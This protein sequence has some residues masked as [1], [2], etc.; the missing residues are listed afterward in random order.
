MLLDISRQ[1]KRIIRAI[2]AIPL[3]LTLPI[4]RLDDALGESWALPFQAC[5]DWFV[6]L[7]L[8]GGRFHHLHLK[9]FKNI[10]LSVV[11]G[12]GRV[13]ASW[14]AHDKFLITSAKT[15]LPLLPAHW[16]QAVKAGIHL[17]QAIVIDKKATAQESCPFPLC[18]GVL[19]VEM[20]N[21]NGKVWYVITTPQRY[22]FR[23]T[24]YS[25]TN[26]SSCGKWSLTMIQ[27]EPLVQTE[28]QVKV[29]E[30]R[31]HISLPPPLGPQPIPRIEVQDD[32]I[33]QFRRVQLY[34]PPPK[35]HSIQEARDI[36]GRDN[37]NAPA[38]RYLGWWHLRHDMNP[39]LA[40]YAL[41]KAAKSSMTSDISISDWY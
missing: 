6:S 40:I 5:T 26:S 18:S 39:K 27:I 28:D 10:L 7:L 15:G 32:A 16:K 20:E 14:V 19:K 30:E 36:L 2:E 9:A 34:E 41:E 31:A 29:K 17:H 24:K 23:V 38:N 12:N 35:I 11:F 33:G 25:N 22:G 13:G 37:A 1:M 3:H 8:N 21:P 4:I